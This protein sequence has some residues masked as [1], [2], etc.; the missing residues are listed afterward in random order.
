M[1]RKLCFVDGVFSHLP[2][3]LEGYIA[4]PQLISIGLIDLAGNECYAETSSQS[5]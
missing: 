2:M 5:C 3:P 4:P 1:P